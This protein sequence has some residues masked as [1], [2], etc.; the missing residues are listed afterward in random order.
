MR[1]KIWQRSQS[2]ENLN[3]ERIANTP[4]LGFPRQTRQHV[5]VP[6]RLDRLHCATAVPIIPVLLTFRR[7]ASSSMHPTDAIAAYCRRTTTLPG[8]FRFGIAPRR[9]VSPL[10]GVVAHIFFSTPPTP[11]RSGCL[12]SLRIGIGA[13]ELAVRR[14]GAILRAPPPVVT[15]SV[16]V[17]PSLADFCP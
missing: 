7:A 15:L 9:F 2:I 13:L 5:D 4:L 6:H 14:A 10:H 17:S 12:A 16:E 8:S 11:T 1:S 3:L